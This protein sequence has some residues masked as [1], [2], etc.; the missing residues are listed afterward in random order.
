MSRSK[1]GTTY[2]S[3]DYLEA[4]VDYRAFE[5]APEVG[6]VP[7]RLVPLDAEQTARTERLLD[8]LVLISLHEHLGVFPADLSQTP[9]LVREGRM[10]TAFEGLAAGHWDAVFDNL[11]D[12]ICTIH[13]R[14]GWKWTEVLHDLGM[15]LCDLAHQ[16]FV[17]HA[18]R[19]DD[20]VRAHHEGRVAW[21]ASMEGAAMIENELDRI[22]QLYGFGVRALG[23]TYSE[24]N[25]LGSGLREPRDGG[26][27]VFGRRAVE[28][29]NKVGMLIDCSHCGDATTLDTIAASEQPIVLS[30][31]GARELWDSNRLA[32]DE[33]LVA[34]ATKGGVIGIEAAPHTTL[35]ASHPRHSLES[36]MEHFEYVVRQVGIDHVAFGP[37]TVYGDH[38][39][40]HQ[41]YAANLSID[42]SR[43][44]KASGDGAVVG[45]KN[46][47]F[48]KVSYVEGLENPTEGSKNILR[49]LVAHG[50]SDED[51]AKAMGENVLRV[52]RQVW[53]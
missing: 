41:A 35:T 34:C 2:R 10:A 47:P 15:R 30:H 26:L 50:Y 5:L 3:F 16:D 48:E 7:E 51:I 43:A 9:D 22:D 19:V 25:A 46:P 28:R 23:I 42:R 20:L 38:V 13:S 36:F 24:S 31:I 49:W 32:P 44:G 21:V 45:S 14:G 18:T 8:E 29:M 37:D 12:G 17:F 39:G 52:L 6:R 4:G 27:T 40:L 33:V 53:A 1:L 11:M